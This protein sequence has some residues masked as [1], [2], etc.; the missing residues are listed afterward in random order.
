MARLPTPGGDDGTWGGILNDFLLQIQAAD[1]SLKANVVSP[2]HVS[3]LN[4]PTAGY[5]LSYTATG[6]QWISPS[7]HNHAASAITSGLIGLDRLGTGTSGA[8][9]YLRGDSS[10]QVLNKAAVGL[11]NVDNTSDMDKP[12]STAQQAAIDASTASS[13]Q[14]S[15]FLLMGA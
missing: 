3:T 9:T 1:G 11:A 10:W 6:F 14:P 2:V 4:A 8:T 7:A 12:V 15:Q 5:T 13:A